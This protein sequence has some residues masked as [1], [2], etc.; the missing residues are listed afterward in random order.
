MIEGGREEQV[1]GG[2]R[3][4]GLRRSVKHGII[5]EFRGRNTRRGRG[6]GC[7]HFRLRGAGGC[8]GD[9]EQQQIERDIKVKVK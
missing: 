5:V 7:R 2:Q 9:L 6:V 8:H 4:V 1:L 3:G